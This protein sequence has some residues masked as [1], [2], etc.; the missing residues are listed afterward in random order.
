M[1]RTKHLPGPYLWL[2]LHPLT[3]YVCYR[4]DLIE[5]PAS[6]S[7]FRALYHRELRP[8]RNWQEYLDLAQFF[9]RPTEH[10]YGTYIQGKQSLALWYE[11]LK[12]GET[13]YLLHSGTAPPAATGRAEGRLPSQDLA[14][15]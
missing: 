10:F 12:R 5:D 3:T 13:G 15:T 8:P 6:R 7:N 1:E 9:N 11:W 14:V 4:K 2:S